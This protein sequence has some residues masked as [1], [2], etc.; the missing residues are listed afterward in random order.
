MSN[1]I[2]ARTGLFMDS[3]YPAIDGPTVVLDNYA[4]YLQTRKD[5]AFILV[6]EIRDEPYD[7]RVHPYDIYRLKAM[8]IPSKKFKQYKLIVPALNRGLIKAAASR[9][10]DIC[11]AHSPYTA[12][13]IAST[14]ARQKHI[15]LVVTFHTK[16]KADILAGTGSRLLA[17]TGGRIIVDML[18]KASEV[19]AV[20]QPCAGIIREYGYKREVQIMP[21]G[22]DVRP[23]S[24]PA[25]ASR[26]IRSRHNIG[27]D[28]K[29][30]LFTGRLSLLKGIDLALK[31]L[32]WYKKQ[33]PKFKFILIGFGH[34]EQVIRDLAA[35]LGLGEQV[36]LT[37]KITS[38][39][40]LVKYY[41][42]ADLLLFP[43]A[44]DTDS[45][46]PKE[47]AACG[48]PSLLLHGAPTASSF[49]DNVTGFLCKADVES[50]GGRIG[51][52]FRH[53]EQLARVGQAAR[54]LTQTWDQA[55]E[56]AY[57]R[58]REVIKTYRHI[59]ENKQ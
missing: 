47:A 26:E 17:E 32:A 12:G 5:G 13:S 52:I 4:R 35:E 42:T 45:L 24:D 51:A 56:T 50:M 54:A 20:N 31:S 6:P 19:W 34:D 44:Y 49:E 38:R 3:F 46:V 58:Y 57:Q 8:Q 10:I 29:L 41:G 15:P 23:P 53:P 25:L 30:F 1:I 21:N 36:I 33:D 48:T 14:I 43:S 22:I 11:H 27:G 9:E 7:D 28:E 40:L 16:Y 39:E 2:R 55:V 59:R 37:G 18:N